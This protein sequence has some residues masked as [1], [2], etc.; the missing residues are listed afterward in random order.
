[1]NN[2]V[3]S[4]LTERA[5]ESAK[6]K[7]FYCDKHDDVEY[8]AAIHEELS[9]AFQCWNKHKGWFET[10]PKPDGVYFE[11]ADA[12][13]RIMSYCGYKGIDLK[14]YEIETDR[15]YNKDDLCDLIMRSHLE[16]SQY[17]DLIEREEPEDDYSQ[18][19]F[20]TCAKRL[21][22]RFIARIELFIEESSEDKIDLES[23]I[24]YKLKY[25]ATRENK[26]G[27]HEV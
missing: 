9:E 4:E 5:Y 26:H 14:S 27:G 11:L 25:N 7:G 8:L 2:I 21:L 13:I 16:I 23:L 15:P 22:S 20:D 10:S 1:M 18:K 19:L 24:D 17:Y 3:L 12:V 6:A